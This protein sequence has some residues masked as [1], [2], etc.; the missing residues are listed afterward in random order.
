MEAAEKRVM[1]AVLDSGTA[2]SDID[3]LT[4][5]NIK[6]N[7]SGLYMAYTDETGHYE[8]SFKLNKDA[9]FLTIPV[10]I[11]FSCKSSSVTSILGKVI[12]KI[13]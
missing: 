7:I 11:I 6:Q 12:A 13:F 1:I 2:V 9:S 10:K 3:S 5:D 8:V 4:A